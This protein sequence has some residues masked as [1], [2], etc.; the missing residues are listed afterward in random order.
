MSVRSVWDEFWD[1]VPVELV[2]LL[3]LA[4]VVGV[5]VIHGRIRK[6]RRKARALASRVPNDDEDQPARTVADSR[7]YFTGLDP[8]AEEPVTLPERPAQA[9][10]SPPPESDASYFDKPDPGE[11]PRGGASY[12]D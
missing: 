3:G 7:D 9:A 5:A 2:A 1:V 8:A 4:V 12:F 6:K 10:S 11:E